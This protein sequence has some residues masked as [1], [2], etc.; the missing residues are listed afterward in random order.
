M[1]IQCA[2]LALLDL[3]VLKQLSFCWK[4]WR[5]W[6][7]AQILCPTFLPTLPWFLGWRV[8]RWDTL[9]LYRPVQK[10]KKH[11]KRERRNFFELKIGLRRIWYFYI[12]V[13]KPLCL[14][15]WAHLSVQPLFSPAKNQFALLILNYYS[16]NDLPR[17]LDYVRGIADRN[18]KIL[19]FWLMVF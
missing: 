18:L 14:E 15:N 5:C 9:K 2:L 11:C 4:K 17:Q 7:M 6:G 10:S 13:M 19:L 1:S 12:A 3:L 8:P 16:Q